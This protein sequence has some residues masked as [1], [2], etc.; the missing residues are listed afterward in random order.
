M[1]TPMKNCPFCGFKVDVNDPDS[2][3]PTNREKHYTKLVIMY[4]VFLY[5]VTQLKKLLPTGIKERSRKM[6]IFNHS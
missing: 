4:V 5:W 1:L 3:Y 6:D 2:V